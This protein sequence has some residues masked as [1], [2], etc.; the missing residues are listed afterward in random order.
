MNIKNWIWLL[1]ILNSS[2]VNG[3]DHLFKISLNYAHFFDNNHLI[4]DGVGGSLSKDLGSGIDI[5]MS[6]TRYSGGIKAKNIYTA[7][8][9]TKYH[10]NE[11][12]FS[13]IRMMNSFGAHLKKS[14]PISPTAY[15]YLS[16]GGQF[17]NYDDATYGGQF[18]DPDGYS[19][20]FTIFTTTQYWNA[21]VETGY[22]RLLA[23]KTY[24]S[25]SGSYQTKYDLFG[26]QVGLS[27]HFYL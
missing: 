10:L 22:Y 23:N 21:I 1:L 3:Q 18:K 20:N 26:V 25:I 14:M 9:L 12:S 7:D 4:L 19:R 5:V 16:I 2:Y 17:T 24:L 8:E 11:Y 13:T 6:F 27:R 15:F